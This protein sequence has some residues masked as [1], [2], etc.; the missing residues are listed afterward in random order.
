MRHVKADVLVILSDVD[1]LYTGNPAR[2]NRARLIPSVSRI[3]SAV[4][5]CAE[6]QGARGRGGMATKLEAARLA[7]EAGGFAVVANG[8]TPHVLDRIFAGE[9]I[10]TLF[11]PAPRRGR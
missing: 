8:K 4:A 10:G 11:L 9:E 5:R 1:G 2:D 7:T 3:T 6:G